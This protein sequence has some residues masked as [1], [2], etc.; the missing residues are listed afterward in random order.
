MLT[1]LASSETLSSSKPTLSI[2]HIRP[3][4]AGTKLQISCLNRPIFK[5]ILIVNKKKNYLRQLYSAANDPR[6]QMIPRPEMI[7]KLDCKWS[8]TAN[9]PGRKI[10]MAWILVSWIL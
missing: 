3:I 6:P 1:M 4:E 8:R 2:F 7:P 9:D 5:K 10:R